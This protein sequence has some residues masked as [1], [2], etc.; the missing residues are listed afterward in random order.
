MSEET[1]HILVVD[2]EPGIR[3]G[4]QR[5][6]T[7]EGYE[8][9]IAKDGL[10]GLEIFTAQRNF[11]AAFIDLKMPRMDGI[12]LVERIHAHMRGLLEKGNAFLDG[13]FFCPHYERGSVAEYS[14][15][16]E[17]RKPGTGLIEK[18]CLEFD[19]DIHRSYVV[20][21]RLSDMEMARR[22]GMKG[23]LVKTGYGLGEIEYLL[24][25]SPHKP[26]HIAEDLAHAARWIV[27]DVDGNS[28]EGISKFV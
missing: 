3:K 11:A 6:L 12:E 14:R 16:C 17:C 5:I 22:S 24:P 7:A 19:I 1:I 4:C 9:V 2:D 15:A 10:E 8:V 23:I 21:D 27:E 13:V 20:G 28:L 26:A 18:A 25:G